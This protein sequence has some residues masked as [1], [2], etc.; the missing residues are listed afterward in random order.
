VSAQLAGSAR[1]YRWVLIGIAGLVLFLAGF[2]IGSARA[3]VSLHTGMASSTEQTVG[4]EADG[5]TY[6]I[7]L[8]IRWEDAT[9]TSRF[10]GRPDCLPPSNTEVGPITFAAFEVSVGGSTWRQV[11]WVSCRPRD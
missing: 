6:G 9:G 5:W 4:I 3:G 7:P 1:R 8:D 11:V 10:G 2:L